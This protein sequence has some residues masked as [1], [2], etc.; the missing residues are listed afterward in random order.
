MK[1]SAA[2]LNA[3][4]DDTQ[5][6]QALSPVRNSGL[7]MLTCWHRSFFSASS[8]S[9]HALQQ[10]ILFTPY[11]LAIDETREEMEKAW[12]ALSS[13]DITKVVV[14]HFH[15]AWDASAAETA[16]NGIVEHNQGK[17]LCNL[18]S[19]IGRLD[20]GTSHLLLWTQAD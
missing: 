6:L 10:S 12:R 8:A 18:N 4:S 19:A 15:K 3:E 7:G 14:K 13:I 16:R 11:N 1:L 20:P 5:Q 9:T 17:T 2:I